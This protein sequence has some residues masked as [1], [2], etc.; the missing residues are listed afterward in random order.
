MGMVPSS[1]SRAAVSWSRPPAGEGAGS[2]TTTC[3]PGGGG[4]RRGDDGRSC[5]TTMR[6]AGSLRLAGVT[7]NADGV[8]EAITFSCNCRGLDRV[9]PGPSQ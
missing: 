5:S 9:L 7:P 3:C 4:G 8:G 1:R 6:A 2:T